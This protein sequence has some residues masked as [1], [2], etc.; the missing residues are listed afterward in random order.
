MQRFRPDRLFLTFTAMIGV[1]AVLCGCGGA[2]S[3]SP[4]QEQDPAPISLAGTVDGIVQTHMQQN[5]IPGMVVAL[6]KGGSLLYVH[7]YGVTNVAT[8]APTEPGTIYEIG[9]ITKQFTAALIMKLKEQGKLTLDDPVS[10]FLPQYNFPLAVTIRMCLTHTSGLADYTTFP[11]LGDWIKNGVSEPTVLTVVSEA[12]VLFQP[13]TKYSYSN[14]NFFLLGSIIEALTGQSYEA[15]LEQVIL[16]PLSLQNTYYQVPPADQSAT[17][18]TSNGLGLVPARI[19]D[20]SA[21]FSAGAL[22]SNV[23]DLITWDRALTSGK[24]VSAQSFQ[25]M[26]TSNGFTDSGGTSYGLG[27]ALSKFNKRPIVWHTGQIGGFYAENVVFLD[28]GFTL[29][30]L[31]NDQDIDTDPFVLKVMNAVCTSA[32]LSTYC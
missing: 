11:Q 19:W 3:S 23:Y 14:S 30:V 22:S 2:N 25:E 28:D 1:A 13:G 6:A 10:K 7:G 26:T 21:A 24:V 20:R 8:N 15:N 18:Y 17:G 29:V 4:S 5:G 32:Q 16:Q 9:S 31:T 27:L 12:P